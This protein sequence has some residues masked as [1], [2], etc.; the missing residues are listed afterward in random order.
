M[1]KT[2]S[3]KMTIVG[4]GP[5]SPDYLTE[6]GRR[7]IGNAAVLVGSPDLLDRYATAAHE[8]IRF[9]SDIESVLEAIASRFE[10]E[11]IAILVSGDPGLCS[12]ARPVIRRFGRDAF[13]VLPGV[14]SVQLAFAR[15]GLDWLDTRI[16]S[17][18]K[19]IPDLTPEDL[20]GSGNIAILAGHRHSQSW[21]ADLADT[22]GNE[23]FLVVCEDLS[24]QSEKIRHVSVPE[25]R[26]LRISTRSVVLLLKEDVFR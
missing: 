20:A 1:A 19:G 7:A 3:H 24:L 5:G 4:C 10:N 23:R 6:A 13:E 15:L 21:I 18:H 17:A 8:Q 9:G 16:V 2:Q 22:L 26:R 12:L 14:S 11:K 25:F